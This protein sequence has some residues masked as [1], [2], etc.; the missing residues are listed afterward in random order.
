MPHVLLIDDN[1]PLRGLLREMLESR[2]FHVA[3]AGDGA[4]AL[5]AVRQHR[6]DVV[7]CDV[8]M[9]EKD[10][11]QTI[12]ELRALQPGLKVVAMSGGGGARVNLLGAA[13]AFGAAELLQKP[14]GL[15]ALT[16]AIGRALAA[17]ALA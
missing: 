4:E 9:P 17:P 16:A 3:E 14:F 13:R 12:R 7:V 2:S 11:L 1:A 8:L 5:R 10:G 15:D 6:P